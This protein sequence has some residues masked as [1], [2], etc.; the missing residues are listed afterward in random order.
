MAAGVTPARR[1]I[2]LIVA[3]S[4]PWSAQVCAAA[5]TRRAAVSCPWELRGRP[6]GRLTDASVGFAIVI[7]YERPI[8]YCRATAGSGGV[9]LL[10]LRD[11]HFSYGAVPILFGISLEVREGEMLALLGT[12]GAGKSTLLRVAAGLSL[13]SSGTVRFRRPG[14]DLHAGR[15]AP[16]RRPRPGRGRQGRVRGPHRRGEPRPRRVHRPRRPRG[17]RSTA[18]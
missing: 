5:S 11:V 17:A 8:I 10:E 16:A 15:A 14:R 9:G 13:P 2:A 6:R 1:A 4:N 12:N 18:S 7:D 3:P